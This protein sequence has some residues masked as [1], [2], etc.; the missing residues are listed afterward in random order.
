MRKPL[1]TG[2][3]YEADEEKLRQVVQNLLDN[4]AKEVRSR[5]SSITSIIPASTGSARDIIKLYPQLAEKITCQAI[6]VPVST[7]SLI[8]LVAEVKKKTSKSRLNYAFKVA[9]QTYLK[10]ILAVSSQELVSVDYKKSTY[11]AI[12]DTPLTAVIDGNLLNLYAWYDNEWA[13]SQRLVD[14]CHFIAKK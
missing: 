8:N 1:V 10:G 4:S 5:R 14:L 13:Y 3:F 12:V 6:R 7:V 11:S 9:A 2:Q